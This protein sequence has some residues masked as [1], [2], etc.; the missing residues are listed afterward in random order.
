MDDREVVTLAGFSRFR[1]AA[2]T[3]LTSSTKPIPEL[4]RSKRATDSYSASSA[5]S[6]DHRG[7]P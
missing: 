6:L 1:R 2:D 4:F 5:R 3:R 7:A